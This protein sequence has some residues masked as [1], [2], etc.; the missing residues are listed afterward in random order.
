M[1]VF[2]KKSLLPI[3]FFCMLLL[4]AC[5]PVYEEK[6]EVYTKELSVFVDEE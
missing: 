1:F 4:T 2:K 3:I 6:P 5:G